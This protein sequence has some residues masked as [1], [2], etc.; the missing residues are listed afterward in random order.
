MTAKQKTAK[1]TQNDS[2]PKLAVLFLLSYVIL[3]LLG[4]IKGLFH[5]WDSTMFFLPPITGFFFTYFLI[6]WID[7]FFETN[8]AHQWYFSII[9]LLAALITEFITLFW[10][11]NFHPG[12]ERAQQAVI[13]FD[14]LSQQLKASAFTPFILSCILG[15][16]SH[17]IIEQTQKQE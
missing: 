11:Y 9:I 10:F 13:T 4:N 5:A 16:L 14:L 17:I 2:L 1:K 3:F 8:I 15:W 6:D 12:V 7:E